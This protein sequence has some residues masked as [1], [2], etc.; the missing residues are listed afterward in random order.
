M[1]WP[2]VAVPLVPT[3]AYRSVRSCGWVS[4]ERHGGCKPRASSLADHRMDE[5]LG[6]FS[7]MGRRPCACSPNAGTS[8]RSRVASGPRRQQAARP[9]SNFSHAN[10]WQAP[11][12]SGLLYTSSRK[13]PS[14]HPDVEKTAKGEGGGQGGGQGGHARGGTEGRSGATRAGPCRSLA[15]RQRRWPRTKV[16]MQSARREVAKVGNRR[17]GPRACA[18]F[19]DELAT[20]DA[21]EHA[22]QL[23]ELVR[24]AGYGRWRIAAQLGSAQPKALRPTT[25]VA[26][27]RGSKGRVARLQ[28]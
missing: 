11:V 25:S 26:R 8:H 7:S 1:T 3:K 16:S 4:A 13:A 17:V 23:I 22:L 21:A 27:R 5:G 15:I 14:P 12:R 19:G 6:T 2:L 10:M 24:P 9:S 18:H 28:P 20:H